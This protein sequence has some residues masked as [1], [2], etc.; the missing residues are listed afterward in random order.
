MLLVT[1][2]MMVLTSS[3]VSRKKLTYLQFNDKAQQYDQSFGDN[4]PSVTPSAYKIMPYD[5]LYIRVITPDPQWSELFNS[6]PIGAG[7][8]VTQESA[9]LFGYSVDDDGF[10]EIPFVNKVKV[11]G[12]TLAEIKAELDSIFKN[13]VTDA[14]I[15]IRLVNN[16]ISVIGE[17]NAPG[18]YPLTKD[19]MNIFE[20]LSMAG[21]MSAFSDRQKVQLI[22]PSPYGPVIKEFSLADRSILSSEFYYI[23]PNDVIYAIP[24]QGRSFELNATFWSLVLSTITSTLGVLAFFRTL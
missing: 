7:G 20:A 18:R 8:S 5:N 1:V 9:G 4:R 22:R 15:T 12:L 6:M 17:V 13:Y 10:I 11:G 14:A 2:L 21:D 23:M 3:C 16:F 24:M 19:R